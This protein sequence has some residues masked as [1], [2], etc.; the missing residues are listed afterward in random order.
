[1]CVLGL[2]A[3]VR[4]LARTHMPSKGGFHMQVAMLPWLQQRQRACT[5]IACTSCTRACGG[6][7]ESAAEAPTHMT[8]AAG[9]KKG[10][11]VR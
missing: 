1:M 6:A 10:A 5:Y 7:A 3:N 11:V 8:H 2:G 4:V 9:A